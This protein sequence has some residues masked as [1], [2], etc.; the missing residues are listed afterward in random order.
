MAAIDASGS[1]P[2]TTNSGCF[3]FEEPRH[4]LKTGFEILQL[5]GAPC[6][7]FAG[8]SYAISS[9]GSKQSPEA[10]SELDSASKLGWGTNWIGERR[11]RNFLACKKADRARE[12]TS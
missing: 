7:G 12:C 1:V 5:T 2:G 9:D 6:N 8:D 10:V 3:E 4:C 11:N